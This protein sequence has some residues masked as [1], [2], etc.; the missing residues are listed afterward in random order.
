LKKKA[1][2]PKSVSDQK[3][4]QETLGS[5]ELTMEEMQRNI[6]LFRDHILER[7][8]DNI[9]TGKTAQVY[10]NPSW[11]DYCVK[12]INNP[13]EYAKGNNVKVEAMLLDELR[14]FNDSGCR[15]PRVVLY[16]MDESTH[17][18]I[19]EKISGYTLA[20]LLDKEIETP[21]PAG[22]DFNTAFANLEV[23]LKGMHGKDIHHRDFHE[24]NVMLDIKTN[25]FVIIDLGHSVKAVLDDNPYEHINEST[26]E[27]TPWRKDTEHLR[28]WQR[29]LKVFF[30][31]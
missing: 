2:F 11:P 23:F 14:S 25:E 8:G 3:T 21:V 30:N 12:I 15:V 10:T 29:K 9:G 28:D 20:E 31:I 24:G 6:E 16:H 18:Y 1:G 27:I 17:F 13:D 5:D 19:M 26:G 4:F 7:T 22:F